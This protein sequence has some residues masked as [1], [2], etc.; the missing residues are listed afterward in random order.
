M[1]VKDPYLSSDIKLIADRM[2]A[3]G[4]AVPTIATVLQGFVSRRWIYTRREM[5]GD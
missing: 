3:A 1:Y 4:I 2:L 5:L